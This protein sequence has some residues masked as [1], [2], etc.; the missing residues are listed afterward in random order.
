M[1]KLVE[2]KT[3]S[4]NS[5]WYTFKKA[6]TKKSEWPDKV[7][8]NIIFSNSCVNNYNNFMRYVLMLL[9]VFQRMNFLMSFIGKDR[10]LDLLLVYYGVFYH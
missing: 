1:S 10:L 3:R 7:R 2:K 6:T 8:T 5:I 9:Y 4:Q